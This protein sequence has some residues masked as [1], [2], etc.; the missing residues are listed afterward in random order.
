MSCIQAVY[1]GCRYPAPGAEESPVEVEGSPQTVLI[2]QGNQ[3]PVSGIAVIVTEG[4][5]FE[6][7]SRK[8]GVD[9]FT[10]CHAKNVRCMVFVCQ[11]KKC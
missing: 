2:E 9:V 8:G 4:K 1:L 6:P 7:T 11:V 10:G 3:S 5:C